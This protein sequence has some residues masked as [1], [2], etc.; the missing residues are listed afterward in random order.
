MLVGVG[1]VGLIGMMVVVSEP[2]PDD[3]DPNYDEIL[4]DQD[5]RFNRWAAVGIGGS[6]VSLV[7][8]FAVLVRGQ[9]RYSANQALNA[10]DGYNRVLLEKL[11]QR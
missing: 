11:S 4:D 2:W 3:N 9:Y 6:L 10:A 1:L 8:A 5:A 7:P